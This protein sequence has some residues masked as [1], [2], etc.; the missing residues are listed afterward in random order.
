MGGLAYYNENDVH[1][2]NWLREL[3]KAGYIIPGIVDARDIRAVTAKD[4]RGFT[5]C[6]F[7]AGIG[8]WPRALRL[9]G[10]PDNRPV[11]TGSCP[12]APFSWAGKE[13]GATD[14]RHLW[15]V[16]FNLIRKCKPAVV[17]GE[18]V[19]QAIKHQWLDA[20]AHDLEKANYAI[21]AAIIPACALGAPHLRERLW[22]VANA[23][24]KLLDRDM[25]GPARPRQKSANRSSGPHGAAVRNANGKGLAHRQSIGSNARQKKPAPATGTDWWQSEPAV[26]RLAYGLPGRVGQLR[27]LGAAVVPQVAAAFVASFMEAA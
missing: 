9:A 19:A 2:A 20:V 26:G 15:P 24:P 3:I 12:C 1:A 8:G 14:K 13:K 7:F 10:W 16:W 17:F 21:G 27:G 6:H 5:Q 18:Q 22:F 23:N 4:L 11:W 25:A